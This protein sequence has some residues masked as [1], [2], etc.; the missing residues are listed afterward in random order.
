MDNKLFKISYD[1]N[2]FGT[3]SRLAEQILRE[4]IDNLP[5]I[6]NGDVN[7]YTMYLYD[8]DDKIEARVLIRNAMEN[9]INFKLLNMGIV[10]EN[11]ELVLT[12]T[13]DLT[14]MLPIPSMHV[15]ACNIYFDK[16]NLKTG[17]IV[18]EKFKVA[19]VQDDIKIAVSKQ[20]KLDIIDK[21]LNNDERT[22]VKG[23]IKTMPLMIKDQISVN[24]FKKVT[25]ENKIS[26]VILLITNTYDEDA[27]L[28]EFKLLL[29]N[30]INIPQAIK[31]V[32]EGIRLKANTTSAFKFIIEKEDIINPV[33]D[34]KVCNATIEA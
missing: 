14:S 24:T 2:D 28:G 18:N 17:T 4:E 29:N 7:F 30:H 33:F 9:Q 10:D 22:L 5:E 27:E 23:Y 11:N 3:I 21:N 15:R 6:N 19:I 1:K 31:R 34:I 32:K 20:T 26:Y 8:L 13:M 16:K 12:Q 25:D